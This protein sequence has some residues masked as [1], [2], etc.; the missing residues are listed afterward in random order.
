MSRN[1]IEIRQLAVFASN[2]GKALGVKAKTLVLLAFPN[3]K[4]TKS[5]TRSVFVNT[6]CV[7]DRN[8]KLSDHLIRIIFIYVNR[9]LKD[10][11]YPYFCN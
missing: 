9:I 5:T 3:E 10:L 8:N 7:Y 4:N 11:Q 1:K 2:S 6:G